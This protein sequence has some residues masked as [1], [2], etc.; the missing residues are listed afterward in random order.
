MSSKDKIKQKMIDN[1][2]MLLSTNNLT[3]TEY[4]EIEKIIFN[5]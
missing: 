5:K 4:I 1:A 3:I 2:I